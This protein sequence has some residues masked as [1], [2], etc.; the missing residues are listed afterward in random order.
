MPKKLTATV[1]FVISCICS[2]TALAQSANLSRGPYM[3][4]ATQTGVIIRW[5]T[6]IPTDSKVSYGTSSGNLTSATTDASITTEHIIRVAGLAPNT[7]YFYSIG[8]TA[9]T[10]QG[11]ANNYFK[12]LP[13]IG[14]KQK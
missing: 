4:L 7:Q 5:R 10:L 3:N 6:D 14:S 2:H 9:Q 1:G 13:N 8:S 11:D 12:T